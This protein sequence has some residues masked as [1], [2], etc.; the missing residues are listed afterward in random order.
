MLARSVAEH[1][2]HLSITDL[3]EASYSE[4]ECN[5]IEAMLKF[6]HIMHNKYANMSV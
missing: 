5:R 3:D 6:M 4:A 1:C 2:T